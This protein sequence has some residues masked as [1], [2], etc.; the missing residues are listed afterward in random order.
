M[1]KIQQIEREL[2]K[3]NSSYPFYKLLRTIKKQK[4][5]AVTLND[6]ELAK[7]LWCYETITVIHEL[8][9]QVWSELI[10]KDYEKAWCNLERIEI[11]FKN[12]KRHFNISDNRFMLQFIERSVLNLQAIYPYSLFSSPEYIY[13]EKRC[14]VCNSVVSLRKPCG[15]K[16]GEIYKGE[17]C[18]RI[19]TISAIL[20]AAIVQAPVNKSNVLFLIDENTGEK[21]DNH[22]YITIEYLM[23]SVKHSYEYWDLEISYRYNTPPSGIKDSDP[24][25]CLSMDNYSDCCKH[26]P[27]IKYPHYIF[28]MEKPLNY[29]V[30]AKSK[31]SLK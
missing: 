25:P 9:N 30:F 24:C 20:G 3:I 4:A 22:N 2:L 31:L 11:K 21:I 13:K 18:H 14:S 5:K 19:V 8:Y 12:L 27:G 26:L 16:V 6:E 10:N 1:G 17:M 7:E 28:I 23:E 15:H 29:E